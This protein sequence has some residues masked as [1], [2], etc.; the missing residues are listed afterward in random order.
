MNGNRPGFG[1]GRG[2]SSDKKPWV[3]PDTGKTGFEAFLKAERMISWLVPLKEQSAWEMRRSETSVRNPQRGLLLRRAAC[4]AGGLAGRTQR[5]GSGSSA[6][7][8]SK[9]SAGPAAG[10]RSHVQREAH[11]VWPASGSNRW[12]H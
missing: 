8:T 12:T 1:K 3:T 6:A 9:V 11:G 10:Q 5:R 7:V 2:G 4:G